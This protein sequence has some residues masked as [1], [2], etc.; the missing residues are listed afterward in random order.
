MHGC[1]KCCSALSHLSASARSLVAN[2][3]CRFDIITSGDS[4][5]EFA[6]PPEGQSMAWHLAAVTVS[7]LAEC[8][9]AACTRSAVLLQQCCAG[10]PGASDCTA[11]K[12]ARLAHLA[13]KACQLAQLSSVAVNLHIRITTGSTF[14]NCIAAMPALQRLSIPSCNQPEQVWQPTQLMADIP[15]F[16]TLDI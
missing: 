9:F 10:R 15:A 5:P 12:G 13:S 4:R 3:A 8:A 7:R 16:T 11:S 2:E 14:A 6:C 1:R